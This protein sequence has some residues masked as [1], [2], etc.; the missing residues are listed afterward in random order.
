MAL[1]RDGR[2]GVIVWIYLYTRNLLFCWTLCSGG[3]GM[4][5]NKCKDS[6][7]LIVLA[8]CKGTRSF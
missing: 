8:T 3:L 7:I 5:L 2:A 4:F 1:L 6:S